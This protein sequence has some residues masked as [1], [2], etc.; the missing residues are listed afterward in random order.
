M[1]HEGWQQRHTE[2]ANTEI[3]HEKLQ[4]IILL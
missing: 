2:Y 1:T 4:I 3:L